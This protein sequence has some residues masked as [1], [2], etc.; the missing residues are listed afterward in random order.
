VVSALRPFHT[1]QLQELRQQNSS[2]P[3]ISL[4]NSA[5]ETHV[6]LTQHSYS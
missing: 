3:P 5:R 4:R 6:M 1:L 2:S